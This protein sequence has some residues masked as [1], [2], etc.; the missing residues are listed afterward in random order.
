MRNTSYT[1]HLH[2]NQHSRIDARDNI[3]PVCIVLDGTMLLFVVRSS[4]TS[5]QIRFKW[6]K[7]NSLSKGLVLG[8]AT[9]PERPVLYIR[10]PNATFP[11]S[12]SVQRRRNVSESGT[13]LPSPPLPFPPLPSPGLPSLSPSLPSLRSRHPLLRLGSLGERLSSPSGSG[14]GPAAK[15]MYAFRG[16]KNAVL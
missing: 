3:L 6:I 12:P 7:S 10:P 14:R 5:T 1:Y 2:C 9:A 8:R 11:D 16:E 4:C 15:R 13:A